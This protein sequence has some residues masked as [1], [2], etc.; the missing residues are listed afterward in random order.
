MNDIFWPHRVA[1]VLS[2][3][4]FLEEAGRIGFGISCIQHLSREF[5][6]RQQRE[7]RWAI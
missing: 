6:Q 7:K 3:A 1:L 4:V 5:Q 2:V